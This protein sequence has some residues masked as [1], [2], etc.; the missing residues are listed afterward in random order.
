MPSE[1]VLIKVTSLLKRLSN[2]LATPKTINLVKTLRDNHIP[3]DYSIVMSKLGFLIKVNGG[4]RGP[5][6]YK[7]N[8][9]SKPDKESATMVISGYN[10]LR[11]K[12]KERRLS[13]H[14]KITS[15]HRLIKIQETLDAILNKIQ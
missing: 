2:Q 15:E 11:R 7:W 9:T 8:S 13:T 12:E 10:A 1:Q 4:T 3:H 5:S 6:T 14:P